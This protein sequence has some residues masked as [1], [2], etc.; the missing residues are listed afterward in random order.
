MGN[1]GGYNPTTGLISY[2]TSVW[3][4]VHDKR[5]PCEANHPMKSYSLAHVRRRTATRRLRRW[6]S[7]LWKWVIQGRRWL[8]EWINPQVRFAAVV[9]TVGLVVVWSTG[10]WYDSWGD[11]WQGTFVEGIGALMDLVVFGVIIGV[12]VGR[13]ERAREMR[14]H[15]ELV[16]DFKK[17]DSEEARYR[18]AGAVRRLN[19]LGR[20]S[21]DF[22][23]LELRK[24]AFRQ[25]D[26]TSIAGSKFYVGAWG[27]QDSQN[28]TV[29]LEVD[30]SNVDCSDVVFSA[31]NPF[32]G[33]AGLH[34]AKLRDCRFE[35]ANLRRATF[36]GA[37]IEWTAMPPAEIEY[38]EESPEGAYSI[39]TTYSPPFKEADLAGVSFEG[40]V[41]RNADFRKAR[42]LR[43]CRFAGASGLEDCWF[44]NDESKEWV[45]R[46]AER[47]RAE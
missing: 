8:A 38:W 14:S 24:F 1:C 17:W 41:F 31:L 35:S 7:Q 37:L 20:T 18:I 9:A 29:L 6:R 10:R 4:D 25:H 45:L 13:R 36:K 2:S 26:I 19:R 3:R 15:Q 23:G 46:Q 39:P 40:V 12:M 34:P 42:N 11:V 43:E 44:D 32:V 21:I 5:L 28:R 27:V 33:F 16:E 22:V 47:A 30:F